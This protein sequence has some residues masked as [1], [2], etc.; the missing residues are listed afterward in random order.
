MLEYTGEE[1]KKP[2]KISK[3]KYIV[4]GTGRCGTVYVAKLLS[5]VGF[6]C[7][8]EAI[9]KHDGMENA[10]NR[11]YGKEPL[12]VSL[13]SKLASAE[14]EEKGVC[15]FNGQ[16]MIVAESSYMAVPFLDHECFKDV[17]VIHVIRKP[18]KVINSFVSGFDY[19]K[20]D[21]LSRREYK[22][23]HEFIYN[24]IPRLADPK[25]IPV[26]RAALYY[27]KWNEMIEQKSKG[28]KYFLY[29][30]EQSPTKLL[31]WLNVESNKYYENTQSN[32]KIGLGDRYHNI[33]QIK[34]A[35]IRDE[36]SKMYNKYYMENR[37]C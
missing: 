11:L 22:E 29:R 21:C 31:R 30:V 36:V 27:V 12:D 10:L 16:D 32:H 13:I 18:M 2:L 23:Y 19:F 15:W 7:T 34:R 1:L 35:D 5:S 14:D 3:L 6:P 33:N 28:L 17:A 24:Y 9:F 37:L 20:D 8:H 26:D 25:L 4:V